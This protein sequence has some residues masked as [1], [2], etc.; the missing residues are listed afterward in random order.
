[1]AESEVWPLARRYGRRVVAIV[2]VVAL[3][4][5]SAAAAPN[6]TTGTDGTSTSTSTSI[7]APP[8][9]QAVSGHPHTHST[10]IDDGSLGNQ[11]TR[12]ACTLLDRGEIK[13][14]FGGP[15]GLATPTYP[16]CQWLVG[17]N[18]FLALTVEPGVSFNDATEDVDTLETITGLGQQAIIANNRYLYFT[19]AG[20][21]YWLLWQQVGDFSSLNTGQLVA[22]AHD[23]LAHVQPRGHLPEPPA[24]PPGPPIYFAGDSTAA[25]PEWAW[26]TYHVTSPRLRTLSEYQV[27]SGLVVP[28]YFDWAHHLLAVVAARR[29]RLVIY[30]G[31]ANDGQELLVGGTYRPV[32]SPAWRAEYAARVGSVMTALLREGVKVLWIGEPAMQ[33]PQLSADMRVI[34]QVYA[35]E[36]AKHPGVTFLNP[37]VI[38]NGPGGSYTG[39]VTIDG[40]PT[41][42]RLDGI[43]LNIAGSIYVADYLA[44]IVDRILGI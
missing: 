25:G 21:T 27:G 24:G 7:G 28:S 39:T 36:A 32:G 2:V 5:C 18:A 4:G 29:P 23:V 11:P 33:D 17:S 19:E 16:Y 40:H 10:R 38:L 8:T 1:M 43:H 12:L 34:D 9:T 31:S 20:T 13:R 30:M 6:G 37:G 3:G 26:A 22:L 35:E 14:E 44:P 42:V 41:Q 15:V